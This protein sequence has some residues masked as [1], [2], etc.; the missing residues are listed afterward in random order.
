MRY[1]A[2]LLL[3]IAI[4]L[5]A[6][7]AYMVNT[8]VTQQVS[9][10]TDVVPVAGRPAVVAVT[11]LAVGL[12]LEP[13]HLRLVELPDD[14]YP[15][16]SYQSIDDVL[17]GEQPVVVSGILAGEVVLPTKLS[18]GV[19]LRGLT[20]RIPE[21]YRAISIPVNEVRGVG[22]FVLP[23]D[24]VDV[25]HTTSIGRRDDLPVTRTLLQNMIV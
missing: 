25:I 2:L 14:A 13:L 24:R 18:T 6:L 12:N 11:D 17:S 23:G 3:L 10:Q 1:R 22:G 21:G 7:A 4:V 15:A 19:L 8:V 20:T 5:G 16:Q 9:Q